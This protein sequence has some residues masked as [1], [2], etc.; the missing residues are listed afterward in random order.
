MHLVVGKFRFCSV[1]EPDLPIGIP[2][3]P[4]D[5]FTIEIVMTF[6]RV[7]SFWIGIGICDHFD[8]L[9]SDDLI[10]VDGEDP[11]VFC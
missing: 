6:K 8:Q 5:E 2:S 3:A 10:A 1:I 7:D 4:L 9:G 11:V